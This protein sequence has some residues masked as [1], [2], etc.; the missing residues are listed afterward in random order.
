MFK[1]S[2]KRRIIFIVVFKSISY[3][4]MVKTVEIFEMK[5]IMLCLTVIMGAC[6]FIPS[7]KM[8]QG[9]ACSIIE[10]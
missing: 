5:Y 2:R 4:D 9:D 10:S 8:S 7:K 3:I 6:S 1:E